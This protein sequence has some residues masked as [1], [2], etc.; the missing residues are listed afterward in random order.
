[1][2]VVVFTQ[3]RLILELLT[4]RAKLVTGNTLLRWRLDGSYLER[5]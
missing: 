5:L 2:H 1:M 4:L 3:I